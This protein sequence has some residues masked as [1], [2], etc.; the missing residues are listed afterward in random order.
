MS[1]RFVYRLQAPEEVLAVARECAQG[2]ERADRVA[3]GLT[4]LMMNGIEHGNL[5]IG[6][7]HKRDLLARGELEQ[8]IRRRLA[9]GVGQV[10][11]VTVTMQRLSDLIRYEISDEGAGFDPQPWLQ[12]EPG[13]KSAPNGRGI[14]LARGQCFESLNFRPPG[15]VV[16]ALALRRVAGGPSG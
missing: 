7:E 4:E 5:G 9:S 13:R 2:C 15:N 8:E 6:Y 1:E 3:I 14:A 10:R 11:R 12:P 16:E